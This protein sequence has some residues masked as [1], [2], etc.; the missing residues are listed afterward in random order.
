TGAA[1]LADRAGFEARRAEAAKRGKLRGLGISNPIEV[2]GG[3][4]VKPG[5]DYSSI[6]VSSDGT[7]TLHAGVM[8]VGQGLETMLSQ[9]VAQR[10]S[11]PVDKV[12]YVQ[13]DTDLLPGGRGNGG[14]SSTGV[15]GACVM[16]TVD[17]AIAKG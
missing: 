14:S 7:V 15:G 5:K 13:G 16:I 11:V 9:L 12:R 1:E 3:P 8:S 10:L 17:N 2:A 6:R 4:F